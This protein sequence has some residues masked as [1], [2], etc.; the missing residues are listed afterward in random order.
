MVIELKNF[1]TPEAGLFIVTLM[2][3]KLRKFVAQKKAGT[4]ITLN[5]MSFVENCI[6][7]FFSLPQNMAAKRALAA[8]P[9]AHNRLLLAKRIIKDV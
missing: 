5:K 2:L 6:E 4:L 1:T 3:P 8:T 7:D 9:Y